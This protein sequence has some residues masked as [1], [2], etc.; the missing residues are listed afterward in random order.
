MV[1]ELFALISSIASPAVLLLALASNPAAAQGGPAA[2]ELESTSAVPPVVM[3]EHALGGQALLRA[4][5]GGGF[6]LYMRHA[7]ASSIPPD[8]VSMLTA[9]GKTQAQLVGQALRTLR[10]PISNVMASELQRA[11]DSARL[12]GV[13]PVQVTPALNPAGEGRGLAGPA[14]RRALLAQVPEPGTNVLLVSHRHG[15]GP[16][17]DWLH[18]DLAEVAVYRPDGR[19]ASHPVARI[20]L[21]QWTEMLGLPNAAGEPAR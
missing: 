6:V 12:L 10:I 17:S 7:D 4:L 3:P 18:I 8:P 9:E 2:P 19:G 21:E 14:Q 11:Q 16:R 15:G 13:G 20:T 1:R 5:R